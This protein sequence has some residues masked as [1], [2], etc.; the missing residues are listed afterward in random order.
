MYVIELSAH[1]E[2][3]H[4]RG[5]IGTTTLSGEEAT[6]LP[7]TKPL[8]V[9]SAGFF[10]KQFRPQS[11]GGGEANPAHQHAVDHLGEGR[12]MRQL[13]SF[14]LEPIVPFFNERPAN[15]RRSAKRWPAPSPL[16]SHSGTSSPIKH[17]QKESGRDHWISF[18]LLTKVSKTG[19]FA[20]S[21]SG[22]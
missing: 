18:R 12:N 21:N 22:V 5:A 20:S 16:C 9:R 10:L 13:Y 1:H 3:R 15:C 4:E 14:G 2:P 19:C 7:S 8:I 11:G 6:L 17:C